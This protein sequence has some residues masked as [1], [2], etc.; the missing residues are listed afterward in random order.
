MTGV[1]TDPESADPAPDF[2]AANLKAAADIILSN[3]P[4]G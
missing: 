1:T 4:E 2:V 3:E